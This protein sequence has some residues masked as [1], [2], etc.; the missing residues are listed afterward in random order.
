MAWTSLAKAT[1]G[2]AGLSTLGGLIGSSSSAKASAKQARLNR[3]FQERMS[4]TAY[5]RA[6][7][8]LEAA[9]LNRILAFGNPA[10]TP[11]GAVGQVPDYGSTI[12]QGISS[13]AGAITSA[14]TANMQF[15][16]AKKV[17]EETSLIGTKAA[18]ELEQ[19]KV[20]QQI[21]PVIAKA[22]RDFTLLTEYLRG[23]AIEDLMFNLENEQMKIRKTL[24]Q[25]LSE[26][27]RSHYEGTALQSTI[28]G[29]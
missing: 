22:G 21:G 11:G 23:G 1:L 17:I 9:G 4:S 6:A 25:V 16:S 10:S 18:K 24:D 19:T 14:T 13:G 5:Q 12:A 20:W 27:Y 8:D 15:E 29:N 26:I 3:E 2:A 28:R 7:A